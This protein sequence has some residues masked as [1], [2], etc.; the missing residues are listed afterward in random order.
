MSNVRQNEGN[1]GQEEIPDQACV[2][3]GVGVCHS[4]SHEKDTGQAGDVEQ[5]KYRNAVTVS[6][7]G[8]PELV[9]HWIIHAEIRS[10]QYHQRSY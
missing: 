6:E 10:G 8:I 4:P 7:K 2:S 9:I 3:A 5:E 1:P